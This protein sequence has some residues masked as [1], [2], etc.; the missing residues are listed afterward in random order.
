MGILE[1]LKP[2]RVMHY[3]EEI[4]SIPHGSGNTD[5]ISDYCVNVAKSLRLE[6]SKDKHNNVIIRKPASAGYEGHSTV[7]LQGHL[8]MV[9]EKD[10]DCQIDFEKDGLCLKVDGD[11]VYA[12][13]TT[14]GGD[15]GIAV[16][17]VLAIL[18]DNT[19]AHPPIEALFTTDEETGMYGA[20]GLDASVLFG[21][22]LIN[23][24]SEEEGILTAGCAGGARV[25][26]KLPLKKGHTDMPCYRVTV[27]GLK[28]GH[29]GVEIDKG[30][31]NSNITMGRF[32]NSLPFNYIIGDIRGGLKDNAIPR[33]TEAVIFCNGEI[34]GA[35]NQFVKANAV[36]TDPDLSISVESISHDVCFDEASS[37][38][39][40]AFLC[41]VP[42]G[43][44][45]MSADIEGLVQTSLN[46][47]VLKVEND[48]LHM[49]FAA[50]SSVNAEKY[51]L[52]DRLEKLTLKFGG[53][54]SSHAHYP[55]WEYRKFSP[56]RDTMAAV[57]E[58]MYG[59]APKIDVIHAGLEC[60]LFSDKI[61]GL[62]AVSFGPN[63]YD[64]HTSREKM[65]ISSV[66]RTYSYLLEVLA[67]L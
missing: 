13:G 15:D 64:I 51:E 29:S 3:F 67:A 22:T 65:S 49:T 39:I 60:G 17:M 54:Y 19:L 32:L 53:V 27:G 48:T 8:D 4:C 16:A 5:L 9:C 52:L 21:K 35:A 23:I 66:E 45:T 18:E 7:I 43:I 34:H 44:Q 2:A 14:L 61:K 6:V 59:I 42:N 41:E 57:Y 58:K 28:G 36:A 40:T 56:L 47:G 26:I 55:A 46:M 30:R 50:R 33:V 20:E 63:L 38:I 31:L 11:F 37:K 24:D 62:D 12:D 1:G 10:E 25:D